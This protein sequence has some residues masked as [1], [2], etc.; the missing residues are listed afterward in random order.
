MNFKIGIIATGPML[1]ERD[2]SMTKWR[3]IHLNTPDIEMPL[4]KW[5]TP[6]RIA[7]RM[8]QTGTNELER[9]REA[10]IGTFQDE[11]ILACLRELTNS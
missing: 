9:N 3:L 1:W 11:A 5:M 8:K 2:P 10:G 7:E 6:E 4:N